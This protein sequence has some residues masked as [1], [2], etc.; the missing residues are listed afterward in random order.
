MRAGQEIIFTQR[1]LIKATLTAE[2]Y[3]DIG[4]GIDMASAILARV[5]SRRLLPTPLDILQTANIGVSEITRIRSYGGT[6]GNYIFEPRA[7]MD[8][9]L[10]L[11]S[12][13]SEEGTI[14]E[15]TEITDNPET[16]SWS[17]DVES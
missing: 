13:A 5:A 12:E 15:R 11:V 7:S 10:Y 3:T 16:F 4:V 1:S 9:M 14:I 2:C 17:V 8:V 6:Q